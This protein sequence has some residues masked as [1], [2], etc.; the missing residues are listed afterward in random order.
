MNL[1][2][3]ILVVKYIVTIISGI[4][5][6]STKVNFKSNIPAANI[7]PIKVVIVAIPFVIILLENICTLEMSDVNLAVIDE[8]PNSSI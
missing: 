1:L 8:T 3:P 4:V 2:N 6:N 5:I 7:L